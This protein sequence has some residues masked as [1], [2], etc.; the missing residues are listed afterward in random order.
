MS[1]EN[2]TFACPACG[3]HLSVP[4]SLAGVRGPCPQCHHEIVAPEPVE[5]TFPTPFAD[6]PAA[7]PPA[8][9]AAPPATA[10][11]AMAVKASARHTVSSTEQE[12]V[13]SRIADAEAPRAASRGK[14][15]GSSRW[16]VVCGLLIILGLA[17][18]AGLSFLP[19]GTLQ[20]WMA[21]LGWSTPG[22]I[23]LPKAEDSQ[24]ANDS[25]GIADQDLSPS[26]PEAAPP[27][28]PIGP[29]ETRTV[30]EAAAPDPAVPAAP[31]SP[32]AVAGSAP[33][34]TPGPTHTKKEDPALQ[35]TTESSVPEPPPPVQV[36]K[37][38]APPIRSTDP[39]SLLPD[40]GPSDEPTPAGGASAARP[41]ATDSE[42]A[43]PLT[44]L[45]GFLRASTWKER[46]A[47]SL[48]PEHVRSE[49]AEYYATTK[50][51]PQAYTST[52]FTWSSPRPN[53]KY[54][55]NVFHVT[56]PDLPQGFPVPVEQTDRGWK[57]DWRAFVEFRDSR[58]KKFFAKY[59]EAPAIFRVQLLR[60]HYYDK[61]V[62]NLGEK[63]CFRVSIPI[64][65]HD[66]YVFVDKRD[67]LAVP[68][69]AGLLDW[70]VV[71]HVMVKL[72]WVKGAAGHSYVEL[73][74]IPANSWRSESPPRLGQK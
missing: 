27:P 33:P 69:L 22:T 18:A 24:D 34:A 21:R 41:A 7:V 12:P 36:A 66:G 59:Q 25:P 32:S 15:R 6:P 49:M 23:P 26:P 4:R 67:S 13:P 47:F 29:L 68:K 2:Y 62:P 20:T 44:A 38:V 63:Y 48:N 17:A 19:P 37:A 9:T 8:T 39:P 46:L 43:E 16:A 30:P 45:K 11:P 31:V 61:D 35:T 10:P 53:S 5:R 65:G 60:S 73:R 28:P 55:V 3:I 54:R 52:L 72:K 40:L 58:L 51:G 57:I 14:R 56:F 1:P 70:E 74:D 50:D 42:L 71:H 64:H